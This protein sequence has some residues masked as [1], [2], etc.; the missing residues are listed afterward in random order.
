MQGLILGA[1]Y[2]LCRGSR[3][4]NGTILLGLAANLLEFRASSEEAIKRT[5][6]QSFAV[7][8]PQLNYL[9]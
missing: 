7:I 1:W 3:R 5:I 2:M 8:I 4:S 6:S 9:T